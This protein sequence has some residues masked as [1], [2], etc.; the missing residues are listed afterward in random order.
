MKKTLVLLLLF[1][2]G[3][4]SGPGYIA[5]CADNEMDVDIVTVGVHG[6]Y[7]PFVPLYPNDRSRCQHFGGD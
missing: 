2:V 6:G 5:P 1:M 3:C 4:A 7:S